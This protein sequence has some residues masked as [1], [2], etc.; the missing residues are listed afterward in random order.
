METARSNGTTKDAIPAI[1]DIFANVG[2]LLTLALTSVNE[3]STA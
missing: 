3:V 2:K 1:V